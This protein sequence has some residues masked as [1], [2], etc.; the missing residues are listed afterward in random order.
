MGWT[1]QRSDNT[2][3]Y[4]QRVWVSPSGKTSYGVVRF[5]LPFPVGDE[6]A[7]N[8]FLAQL[9]RDEGEAVLLSESKDAAQDRLIFAAEGGRYRL[10]GII[11]T[12]GFHGWVVYDGT[13]RNQSRALD[14][15]ASAVQARENTRLGLPPQPTGKD[16]TG[17]AR[18]N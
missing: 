5:N 13:L 9:R 10:N 16:S 15:L 1:L 14:E 12:R 7:L 8:G 4:I 17:S 11:V 18:R 6:I 2:A 3:R